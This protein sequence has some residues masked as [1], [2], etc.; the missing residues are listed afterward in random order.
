[1]ETTRSE[2]LV[3]AASEA[4]V[5]STPNVDFIRSIVA[6][7]LRQGKYDTIVTRFPPEPNGYLHIGHAKAAALSFGIAA[8]TGGRCHLRFDDTNPETEDEHYVASIQDSIRW[9]GYDWGEHLYFASDYFERMYEYAEHLV[10]EGLAYVDS[11]SEEEIRENRGSVTEPG[12]PSRFRDRT[13]EENLDLLRRMRA[14]EFP[15]GAHV[16][17]ARIDMAASNMTLRDPILY[18]IRHAT[19]YRTGDAWCIYPL[20]DFAHPI[21][22][23][24]EGITHSL[25]TLEFENNRPLYDWVVEHA[26]VPSRPHQYEFARGNL[27]Y[28]VMSKRKLLELV[29]GGYVSGW[30][31]PRMPTIAGLRRRGVTPEAI[32]AFWEMAGI[33][34]TASRVDIGKLEYAIRDDLNQRAPRVLCVLRPLKVVLTN[35]PEGREEE[36]DAPSFPHDVPREGSRKVPFS[37]ELY[38]DRDD[39]MENPPKGFHRLVPG[40]EVRLRYAYVIRCDEVV[41]DEA[42]EV[43]ELRCGYYPETRGGTSPEGRTVK[44]TIQWVSAAHAVPCE[45][46]LYD[47]LF[48]VPDPDAAGGDFKDYLNPESLVVVTGAL[49][50]PSVKDDPAG[51]RYQFERVGYFCSDTVDGGPGALVFNRTVTLRDTWARAAESGRGKPTQPRPERERAPKRAGGSSG[52]RPG[53]RAP[54]PPAHRTPELA[55]RL[56]RYERELG[57]APEEAEILTRDLATAELFEAALGAG[58]SARGAANWTIHELP[59]VAG[60]R[61]LAN[62]PFGGRELGELVVLVEDGTLSGTAAREVLAV[63]VEDGGAP[64]PIVQRLGLRQVSDPD[65]LAPVVDAVL[66]AN[67]AK[68][69]EYRGGKAGLLGFFIGQVMRRTG[70]KANPELVREMVE[71]RLNG[72]VER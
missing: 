41:K 68:A 14:G 45:V 18:R 62:L 10:R 48:T 9:L 60:E 55:A 66:A 63:M 35:Y 49:I 43:T 69:A 27:D 22:D 64:A 56:E 36:L 50:E 24:I 52:A 37:R 40:G 2:G 70:G 53:S 54:A 12:R 21:E 61:T 25:C 65:A 5:P 46:R 51:S 7:D 42:G 26:P 71:R 17:R 19:H 33:A 72:G 38:I 11:Q 29:R 67:A 58:A 3:A 1:M 34:K 23:A 6:D 57:I 4:G 16:L 13:P 20:Y 28:T 15:D 31:D 47:R 39:F 44:G 8:E 32:R 30:D 59:R